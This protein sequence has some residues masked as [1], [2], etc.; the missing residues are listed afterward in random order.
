MTM[1]IGL[2]TYMQQYHIHGLVT[3]VL[4][5]ASEDDC[6]ARLLSAGSSQGLN[7]FCEIS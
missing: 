2:H 5:L 3:I 6:D 4:K 1:S 7:Q